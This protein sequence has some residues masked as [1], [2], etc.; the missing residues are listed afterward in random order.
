M[1]QLFYPPKKTTVVIAVH[2]LQKADGVGI[3]LILLFQITPYL[4]S[5]VRAQIL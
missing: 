5:W 2:V 1:F 4:V 3:Y